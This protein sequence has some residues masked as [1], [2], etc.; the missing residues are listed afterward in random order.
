MQTKPSGGF[1]ITFLV[2]GYGTGS[3][4]TLNFDLFRPEKEKLF[5]LIS[6]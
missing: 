3:F 6:L 1:V 5:V 2:A 4:K